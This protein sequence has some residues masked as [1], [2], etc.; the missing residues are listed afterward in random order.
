MGEWAADWDSKR[1]EVFGNVEDMADDEG[2]KDGMFG[3]SFAGG[4]IIP[5]SEMQGLSP[6]LRVIQPYQHYSRTFPR[7][8]LSVWKKA[9]MW[10]TIV[11]I[12]TC[13]P[14]RLHINHSSLKNNLS[15]H[16]LLRMER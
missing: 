4:Q 2:K 6:P 8:P 3:G 14:R 7:L 15:K 1:C 12:N 10:Q 9:C 5:R 13:I 11:E 16:F